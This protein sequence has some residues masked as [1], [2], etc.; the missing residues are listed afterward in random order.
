MS[1]KE[2]KKCY[3]CSVEMQFAQ[4]VPFRIKGTRGIWKLMFGEWAELGE[5]M[6]SFDV[7]LCPKC[8]HIKM[9]AGEKAKQFL[10]KMTPKAF[11]KKCVK[12]SEEIPI[13]SEECPYC[14]A[15]QKERSMLNDE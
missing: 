15:E 10:L 7:Y 4:K 2:V 9:F 1:E 8:G 3:S 11:L 13:A 14:E 12:C 5:E 6:L